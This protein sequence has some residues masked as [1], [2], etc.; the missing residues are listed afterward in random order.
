MGRPRDSFLGLLLLAGT[1]WIAIETAGGGGR[2]PVVVALV[3]CSVAG[4][5]YLL[6]AIGVDHR[7]DVGSVTV[8]R[9]RAAAGVALGVSI[10]AVATAFDPASILLL[11]LAIGVCVVSVVRWIRG[12]P[13]GTTAE[14]GVSSDGES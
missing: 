9:I 12:A 13:P 6:A 5:A 1:G 2:L 7:V 14:G 11:A 4:V 3:G 8:G 10:G